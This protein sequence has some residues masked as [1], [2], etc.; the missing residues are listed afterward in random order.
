MN[1]RESQLPR[2]LTGSNSHVVP[3]ILLLVFWKLGNNPLLTLSSQRHQTSSGDIPPS[4]V[5]LPSSSS[6]WSASALDC[7]VGGTLTS[8][9]RPDT[10]E[11]WGQRKES[12][13]H[14]GLLYILCHSVIFPVQWY[15]YVL[16][17]SVVEQDWKLKRNDLYAMCA[18]SLWK[19][20]LTA[21]FLRWYFAYTQ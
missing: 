18:S 15:T 14:V 19:S 8:G 1:D 6:A 20:A 2:G 21:L 9:N 12:I 11:T 13:G 17:S 10:W 16:Y 3:Y 7:I 5:Q 4:P